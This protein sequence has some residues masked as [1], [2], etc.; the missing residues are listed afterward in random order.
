MTLLTD[1]QVHVLACL[2]DALKLGGP[3]TRKELADTLG[4]SSPNAAQQHLKALERK[5]M[6]QLRTGKSRGIQILEAGWRVLKT[7]RPL[8]SAEEQAWLPRDEGEDAQSLRRLA[9]IGRVAAGQPILAQSHIDTYLPVTAALFHPAADYLLRVTGESMR[10]AGILDGDL[11][12]VHASTAIPPN[13]SIVVARLE[14]AVT[15]KYF[16]RKTPD[17]P[18]IYLLPANHD[19]AYQPIAVD[20]RTQALDIEGLG[21]G[22][23]RSYTAP[24]SFKGFMPA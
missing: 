1:K 16:Y 8:S 10:E 12:A 14:D 3:P 20:L 5:G 22:V 17:D 4:F 21:V 15:V 23:I 7:Q 9:V 2:Y 11:L 6:I 24:R 19:P 13:R 18:V